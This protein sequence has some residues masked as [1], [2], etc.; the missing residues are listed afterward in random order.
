MTLLRVEGL[1]K[2]FGGV[3]AV[4]D[5]DFE[6]REG[7]VQSIIGPNG[8]GKTTL[9]N[10]ITG[11]YTPTRGE[12]L[13]EGRDVSGKHPRHL[14]R[15]GVNRTFQN[16]EICMNMSAVENVMVGRHLRLDHRLHRLER[17]RL[18]PHACST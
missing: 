12:V 8:A 2:H 1:T 3:N 15:L 5:L 13:F 17:R 18:F 7:T 4:E 16:L 14:A 11:I 10:L 6:V 9:F